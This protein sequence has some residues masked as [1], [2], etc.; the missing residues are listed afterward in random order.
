MLKRLP[1]FEEIIIVDTI[2]KREFIIGVLDPNNITKLYEK[3]GFQCYITELRLLDD[4][5]I[6]QTTQPRIKLV[7]QAYKPID[8]VTQ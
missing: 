8:E 3:N 1:V 4:V 2:E 6:G 7:Y 5:L